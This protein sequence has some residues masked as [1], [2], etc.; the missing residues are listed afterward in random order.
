MGGHIC[1]IHEC[2]A[3]SFEAQKLNE[4][5][6]LVQYCACTNLLAV[7]AQNGVPDL[8]PSAC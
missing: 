5:I 7:Q 6:E 3:G 8:K 4:V 2:M 1:V